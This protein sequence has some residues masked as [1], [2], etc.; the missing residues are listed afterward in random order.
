MANYTIKR[1]KHLSCNLKIFLWKEVPNISKLFGDKFN[2]DNCDMGKMINKGI[3]LYCVRDG[4]ITG[5]HVSFLLS[6]SFDTETKILQQQ[7]FYVKPD[8]GRT[9]YHL[10]KKFIDI[11]KLQADHI[12]TMLTSHTNIKPQTLKNMGFEELETLYRMEV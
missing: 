11:G 10:F 4:E 6:S 1:A 9:A 3:V 8:S 7:L 2:F 12:I 5:I